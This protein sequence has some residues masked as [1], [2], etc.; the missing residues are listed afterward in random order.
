MVNGEHL[1]KKVPFVKKTV[2]LL[3]S[4]FLPFYGNTMFLPALALLL[5]MFVCDHQS[6]E[7][8]YVFRDCYT[9]CW[10]GTHTKYIAMSTI[11]ILCYEPIAAYSRPL[12]QQSRT[13]LN[14]KIKP[15]F[16]LLKTC[17]Q[18]LLIAIGKSL[19]STSPLGHGV[20]Y[21]IL[22]TIFTISI[23]KIK[24]FNYHRC[25]LWE[26]SSILA[27]AYL[28]L[29]ATLSYIGNSTNI[30]WFIGLMVGWSLIFGVSIIVQN[31]YMP[32]LL[33]AS[34]QAVG[35]R[36]KKVQPESKY[37]NRSDLDESGIS[38]AGIFK[39]ESSLQAQP[40]YAVGNIDIDGNEGEDDD[41]DDAE[42]V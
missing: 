29:L 14:L 38:K 27:V 41:D 5:D 25:N 32:N 7:K 8:P 2:S 26:F 11:A 30:G 33:I 37:N 34:P 18:I 12:W 3:N 42:S 20:V 1:L 23:Y 36:G 4:V 22:I 10:E 19:Q 6:Q 31:K 9:V 21:T 17:M 13:G 28:S 16:L 24:P 39:E 40:V 15:F 35:K